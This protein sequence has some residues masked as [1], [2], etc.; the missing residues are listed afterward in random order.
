MSACPEKSTLIYASEELIQ[1]VF[2]SVVKVGDIMSGVS[3]FIALFGVLANSTFL[4]TVYRVPEMRTITNFYLVN[5]AIS[6]MIF[7]ITNTAGFIYPR[8]YFIARIPQT[9]I[10]C[11]L[12]FFP[13]Y[14]AYFASIGMVTLVSLERFLAI[15]YPLKHR[16]INSKSRTIVLVTV[17]WSSAAIL[18]ALQIPGIGAEVAMTCIVWPAKY[19]QM[20]PTVISTCGS[21]SSVM[22]NILGI[23]TLT[24]FIVV[25][26]CNAT[27]YTMIIRRLGHR[28]LTPEI[29]R[30]VQN[31]NQNV[32]NSVAR[33]LILNGVTFLVLLS[34]YQCISLYVKI[35]YK[36]YGTLSPITTHQELI[37]GWSGILMSKFNSAIN[38]VIYSMSNSRYRKAFGRAIKCWSENIST[39]EPCAKSD[40]K[41]E[42]EM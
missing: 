8:P 22:T 14:L 26:L 1:R 2:F 19:R 30:E 7:I 40:T 34:V 41:N 33:M 37:I 16:M 6:D 23:T 21:I 12:F 11:I 29:N 25:I 9:Q 17:T 38:P 32:R 42:I 36:G 18:A 4:M 24:L 28:E 27:F 13:V 39:D 15:C 5:L 10:G 3:L 35:K 31:H 20:F